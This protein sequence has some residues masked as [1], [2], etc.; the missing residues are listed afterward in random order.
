MRFT[1][2]SRTRASSSGA[3]IYPPKP[4]CKAPRRSL[5]RWPAER[6][7]RPRPPHSTRPRPRPP[8]STTPTLPVTPTAEKA[9][10]VLAAKTTFFAR[11]GT[12]PLS[13]SLALQTETERERKKERKKEKKKERNK[14]RKKQ[15]KKETKKERKKEGRRKE[16]K[17]E[18]R[19][20]GK[21]ERRK[22]EKKERRKEGNKKKK[23]KKPKH[24]D[25]PKETQKSVGTTCTLERV[26]PTKKGRN[27]QSP[28]FQDSMGGGGRS[29][30]LVFTILL[31]M[32]PLTRPPY[33]MHAPPKAARS[34]VSGHL[35]LGM[36]HRALSICN[37][38]Q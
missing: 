4:R 7:T 29:P 32:A 14:E 18:R 6:E 20:E 19:K 26:R 28:R 27:K 1:K 38:L 23:E 25:T 31:V 16:G 9:V 12:R 11:P 37:N 8:H 24:A 15:R 22:E 33:P 17:K 30:P 3:R 36:H 10:G 5:K 2:A 13:T 35:W 21:K 34:K